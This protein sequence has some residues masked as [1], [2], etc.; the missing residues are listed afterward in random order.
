M[1]LPPEVAV[2]DQLRRALVVDDDERVRRFLCRAIEREGYKVAGAEDKAS[3]IDAL[4]VRPGFDV[5]FIDLGLPD[6]SGL[7]VLEHINQ[8]ELDT[9]SVIVT[10]LGQLDSA[11]AALRLGAS[12]Y[13][14]KPFDD[15]AALRSCLSRCA[16]AHDR[17]R[18]NRELLDELRATNRALES[19]TVHDPLTELFNHAYLREAIDRE[20]GR[21][22]K[23]RVECAL[24]LF[25]L[26]GLRQ[27]NQDKGHSGGDRLLGL[28]GALLGGRMDDPG[29][30]FEPRPQDIV[31]RFSGDTFAMLLPE[32]NVTHAAAIAERLRQAVA[33]FHFQAHDFHEQTI[34]V[35][36]ASFPKQASNHETFVDAASVALYAAKRAGRNRTVT[37]SHAIS[38]IRGQD[39]AAAQV[40][41]KRLDAL[42]RSIAGRA[43]D[44]VFQPIVHA[45]NGHIFAFEALCRPRDKASF[46]NPL[47]LIKAAEQTGRISSLGRV[48]REDSVRALHRLPTSAVLFV[49]IHPQELHDREFNSIEAFMAEWTDQIVFEITEVAGIRDYGRVREIMAQLRGA[50]FR[51]ALDDLGAGYSGLNS[52]SQLQPDFVKLDM[53]LIRRI[54]EP[55]TARLIKHIIEFS[56][57]EKMVVVAEGVETEEERA[58]L[59]DLGAHLLQGYYFSRPVP[60]EKLAAR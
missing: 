29:W 52:L 37:F 24:I 15:L 49:N 58:R 33:G 26:D 23:S 43:F 8:A 17:H 45:T 47:E 27:V 20:L 14:E 50:G 53:D 38:G 16:E 32:T 40:E 51:I 12:D 57:D 36:V 11:V 28:F 56:T 59:V 41:L 35:G 54:A 9:R 34:T 25:E 6:G 4:D 46:S 42:D 21:A 22:D 44:Y 3:A 60:I 2:Q 19:M 1:S 7:D 10:G 13:V 18:T 30:R 55:R 39:A 31:A 5:A 48:L